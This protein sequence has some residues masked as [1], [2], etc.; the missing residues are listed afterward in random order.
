ME[1]GSILVPFES[2]QDYY[3]EFGKRGYLRA[4]ELWERLDRKQAELFTLLAETI[5]GNM[6]LLGLTAELLEARE[7]WQEARR[8]IAG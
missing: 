4:A 1:L 2:T 7:G 8:I 5:R 6:A 3:V